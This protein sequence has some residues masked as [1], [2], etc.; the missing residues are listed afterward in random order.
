MEKAEDDQDSDREEETI[1]QL[2]DVAE[3]DFPF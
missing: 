1:F 3:C 2:T